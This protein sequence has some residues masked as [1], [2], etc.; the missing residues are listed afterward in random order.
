MSP[1]AG[2]RYGTFRPMMT[3]DQAREIGGNFAPS[4]SRVFGEIPHAYDLPKDLLSRSFYPF[5]RLLSRGPGG[6]TSI[7]NRNPRFLTLHVIVFDP[8]MI[9]QNWGIVI[10]LHRFLDT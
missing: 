6:R 3:T 9:H 10:T 2:Y 1:N 4:A 7:R 5:P 8:C